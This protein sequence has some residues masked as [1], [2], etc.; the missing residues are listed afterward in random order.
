MAQ[1][2]LFIF[3]YVFDFVRMRNILEFQKKIVDYSKITAMLIYW[4]PDE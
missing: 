3:F 4:N 1:T 2:N